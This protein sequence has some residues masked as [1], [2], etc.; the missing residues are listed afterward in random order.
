MTGQVMAAWNEMDRSRMAEQE[1]QEEQEEQDKDFGL[2]LESFCALDELFFMKE[3]HVKL[4][5]LYKS[6]CIIIHKSYR[7]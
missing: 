4:L 6:V 5:Y 1:E 2:R 7:I 3:I